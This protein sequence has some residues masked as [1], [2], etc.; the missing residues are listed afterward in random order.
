MHRLDAAVGLGEG[1]LA[2]VDLAP[3]R[4]QPG[5]GAQPRGHP[6]GAGPRELRQGVGEHRRVQLIGL[7]VHI[8]VGARI[9]GQ[10][11]AAAMGGRRLQQVVDQ[12]VLGAAHG[13]KA[14]PGRGAHVRGVMP[15]G[16]R[17]GEHQRGGRRA[18]GADGAANLVRRLQGGR[19]H[20]RGDFPSIHVSTMCEVAAPGSTRCGPG[21]SE[22]YT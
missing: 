11:Q 4:H 2:V 8:D 6:R 22:V 16:V 18:G 7:A 14:E 1:E 17:G 13:V 10:Q 19:R 3:L 9:P 21:L 15:S 20:R 5:D 12:G